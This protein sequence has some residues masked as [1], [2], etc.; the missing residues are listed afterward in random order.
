MT[1]DLMRGDTGGL[2]N[3]GYWSKSV[4][5]SKQQLSELKTTN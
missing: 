4:V 5:S 2:A 1:P 3:E